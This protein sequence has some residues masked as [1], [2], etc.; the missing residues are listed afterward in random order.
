MSVKNEKYKEELERT[1]VGTEN[2][3]RELGALIVNEYLVS[4]DQALEEI[5]KMENNMMQLIL[6]LSRNS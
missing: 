4:I 3:G 5:K 6:W 2:A 1:I